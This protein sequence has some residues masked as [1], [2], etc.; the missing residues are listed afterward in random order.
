MARESYT[1]FAVYAYLEHGGDFSAAARKLSQQ[2]YGK[3]KQPT[4]AQKRKAKLRNRAGLRN[5]FGEDIEW[6]W[7]NHVP[8]R[9]P[10][11][12]NGREGDGKTTIC[13]QIA[14][15]I[16]EEYPEGI[17]IWIASEGHLADTYNKMK[18]LGI[19]ENRFFILENSDE[20]YQFNFAVRQHL[21]ELDQ[22]LTEC[23]ENQMEVLAVFIDSV[24]GISP[25]EDSDSRIKNVLMDINSIVCDKYGASLIYIDHHKKG[26]SQTLL[27]RSVGTTAKAAAVRGVISVLPVSTYVR[28]M[29]VA[30]NNPMTE[31]PPELMAALY[32]DRLIIYETTAPTDS[33]L[34]GQAE[35]WL[36]EMFSKR[37]TYKATDI[38]NEGEELGFSSDVLKKAKK[39]LDID[40]YNEGVGKPWYWTC[41]TFLEKRLRHSRQNELFSD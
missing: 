27:D 7:R 4:K 32:N 39:N 3:Q 18:I 1:P 24:R 36:L 41:T 40:A 30:K 28:K 9:M 31:I 14:N 2:G 34:I 21:K 37:D 26:I 5:R 11:I 13:L 38:Y 19:D 6:L 22:A 33:S 23:K 15:E 8:R 17:I 29:C 25:Y 20:T 10:I 16:L 12:I 35:H